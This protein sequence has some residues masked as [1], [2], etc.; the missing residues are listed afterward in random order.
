MNTN[1]R[2]TKV[3]KNIYCYLRLNGKKTYLVRRT[4]NGH[5]TNMTFHTLRA[6]KE[7]LNT[8]LS[9]KALATKGSKKAN[10]LR[11]SLTKKAPQIRVRV[12]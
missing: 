3:A 4:L 6:A 11:P 10:K 1:V 2:Q 7:W 8:P 9:S 12:R 5:T